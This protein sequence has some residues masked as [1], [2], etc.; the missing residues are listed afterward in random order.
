[1]SVRYAE[2]M[3]A[4]N[5]SFLRGASHPWELVLAADALGIEAIGVC[6]RNTLAGVVRA[7]SA[8][9]D[10]SEAGSKIRDLTG[11]RLVFADGGPELVGAVERLAVQHRAV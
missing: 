3:A 6:D 9:K 4:T 1:M 7:W 5:F 11:C 2:L 8:K 10:L